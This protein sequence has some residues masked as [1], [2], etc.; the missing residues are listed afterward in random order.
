VD[1]S[2]C[3]RIVEA[4]LGPLARAL[5]VG[6]WEISIVYGPAQGDLPV[7]DGHRA[8]ARADVNP[9]YNSAVITIDPEQADEAAE[10]VERLKHELEH[11]VQSPFILYRRL[12]QSHL[13]T[14]AQRD[15]E[16]ALWSYCAEQGV[17]NLDR[18]WN[19]ARAL[20]EEEIRR[21]ASKAR[22]AKR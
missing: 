1:A 11:V 19:G 16:A 12:M 5:G 4:N 3:R 9:P 2:E 8:A 7:C 21:E 6:H 20:R 17:V 13:R 15:Q 22:K 10:V 18:M 14:E